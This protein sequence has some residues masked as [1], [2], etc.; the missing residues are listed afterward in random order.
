MQIYIDYKNLQY[1]TSTKELNQRQTRWYE[2]LSAFNFVI[3]YKKGL[4]N[5]RA[6]ALSR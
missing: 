2:F 4:E 5:A 3:Y 1:F 6:D